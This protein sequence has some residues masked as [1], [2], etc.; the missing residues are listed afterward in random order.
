M[1]RMKT[2][3]VV[4]PTWNRSALLERAI[5]SVLNQ[6]HSDLEVLVCDD[7]ST[8]DTAQVVRSIGD[9]R[10]FWLPGERSGRPAVPRNRGIVA[11]KGEWIAFL[12]DDDVWLPEKLE[13][14][15]AVTHHLDCLAVCSNAF[16]MVPGQ[17]ASG[18]L[19]NIAQERFTFEHLMKQNSVI[20]SSVLINRSLL[21]DIDGFPSSRNLTAIEDYALWLR[22]ASKT[23]FAYCAEPLLVYRDDPAFSVRQNGINERAQKRLVFKDFISWAAQ[24]RTSQSRQNAARMLLMRLNFDEVRD[25]CFKCVSRVVEELRS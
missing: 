21:F 18:F 1:V 23:D 14:Q 13:K 25:W 5:R 8:D 15:L 17:G 24:R 7:G 6:T 22:V 10:V 16:R 12:D 11:S 19:H 9:N 20:C 3:S 2:V 4:I